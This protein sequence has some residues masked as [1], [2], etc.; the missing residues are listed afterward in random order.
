MGFL[1][2]WC[3]DTSLGFSVVNLARVELIF[4]SNYFHCSAGTM[5]DQ[6]QCLNSL[7]KRMDVNLFDDEGDDT[8]NGE[9][10]EV[11][12]PDRLKSWSIA[13]VSMIDNVNFMMK[14]CAGPHA[15]P[16][17]ADERIQEVASSTYT[18]RQQTQSPAPSQLLSTTLCPHS[19]SFCSLQASKA[20]HT[21]LS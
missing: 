11:K 12:D 5:A 17:S 2:F 15:L 3:Y 7:F 13:L 20:R 10:W 8:T 6:I 19:L 14:F 16:I 1:G 9:Y 18:M 21:S 4:N